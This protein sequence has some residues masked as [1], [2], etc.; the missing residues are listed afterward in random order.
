MSKSVAKSRVVKVDA[1][2]RKTPLPSGADEL[3]LKDK[4]LIGFGL[5]IRASGGRYVR[6]GRIKGTSIRRM[7][8]HD[9]AT[10]LPA[11]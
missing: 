2:T 10:S 4:D 6:S 9:D 3:F 7:I 1:A 8:T 5:R 11:T